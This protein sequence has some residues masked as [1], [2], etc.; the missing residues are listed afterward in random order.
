MKAP[1]SLRMRLTAIILVPLLAVAFLVGL[2]QTNNARRTATEVFD[3]SLLSAALAVANDVL[4]SGGDALSP[5]TRDILSDTSGG[6]VFY[7]VYAPDGVIVAGYATPPVGIAATPVEASGP[8]TFSAT[9]QG[10][11]VSGV[12]LQQQGQI[13]G[14]SGVFTT[15]VWQDT[16]VRAGFVRALVTRTIIAISGLMVSLALIVWFGV[17]IGLRPLIDLEDAIA[18]RSSDDLA[19]IQRAVP[20]EVS[21]ITTTLNRLFGQVSRTM[22]AQSDFLSN[23]AHQLRNPIAGILSLAEAVVSA[24]DGEKAKDRAEEL[25]DAARSAAELSQQLLLLDRAKAI[26]PAREFRS[27][28]FANALQGWVCELE[29]KSR[30]PIDL[31]VSQDPG[32]VSC[33]PTMVR[34]ALR[35][36][37]DNAQKHGGSELTGIEVKLDVEHQYVVLCV[38]DDGRGVTTADIGKVRD[39][40]SQVAPTS[41]SGLGLS[42]VEAVAEAHGGDIEVILPAKGLRVVMRLQA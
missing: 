20:V 3:R 10:R 39:R 26:S 4:I 11:D 21:G 7:H 41:G 32:N 16:S 29:K 25:L 35:N 6:M 19:P 30:I 37:V 17:G 38:S 42:I 31:L 28:P 23:A 13:D 18:R 1:F 14:F 34:E 2:W 36:L 33:D 8:M 22:S 5:R 24:P 9:Y 40:F 12:R 15:T 27:I